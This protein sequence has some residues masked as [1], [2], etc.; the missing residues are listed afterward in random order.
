MKRRER[1]KERAP[2]SWGWQHGWWGG[3]EEEKLMGY[4]EKAWRGT[5]AYKRPGALN[6]RSER[7]R[8][9]RAAGKGS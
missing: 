6:D 9:A 7:E 2:W 3:E 5:Q 1:E 4:R 8:A